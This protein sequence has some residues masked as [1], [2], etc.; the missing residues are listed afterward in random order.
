MRLST[1][2]RFGLRIM[3][4]I[5]ADGKDGPVFSRRIA[6]MQNISEAYVDQILMPLRAGGLL[7]SRRGRQGGYQLAERPEKVTILDIIEVLEGKINLV[8]C[9]DNSKYCER[10][11]GCA[12]HKIWSDLAATIREKL[13]QTTLASLVAEQDKLKQT[14]DFVI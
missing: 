11:T 10:V 12:T 6:E 3:L 2:A 8:D 14:S 4:Q 7:I 1:K 5:A 13:S 9:V